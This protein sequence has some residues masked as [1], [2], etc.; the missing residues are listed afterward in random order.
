[1][2][3]FYQLNKWYAALVVICFALLLNYVLY[4]V[5]AVQ[6]IKLLIHLLMDRECF[7]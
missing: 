3:L 5:N 6:E 7:K 4:C 2:S 1:M